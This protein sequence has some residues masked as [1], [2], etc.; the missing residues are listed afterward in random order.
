MNWQKSRNLHSIAVTGGRYMTSFSNSPANRFSHAAFYGC[1]AKYGGMQVEE[2]RF[3][4]IVRGILC[5]INCTGPANLDYKIAD[6]TRT[7]GTWL[8]RDMIQ[9][10][11]D[12]SCPTGRVRPIVLKNSFSGAT[13]KIPGPQRRRSFSDV[14]DHAISCCA[15][16]G[17][18]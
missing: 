8:Y 4:S 5:A 12:C 1:R 10:V 13:R 2:A 16:R 6:H 17:P 3:N 15:Q 18:F 11:S 14:G 9:L 7:R